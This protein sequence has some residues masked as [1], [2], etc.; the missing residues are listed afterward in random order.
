LESPPTKSQ[1]CF[2]VKRNGETETVGAG[3]GILGRFI[4]KRFDWLIV[5]L[6]QTIKPKRL[7]L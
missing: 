2:G 4:F 5:E 1:A 7:A 3:G 6:T